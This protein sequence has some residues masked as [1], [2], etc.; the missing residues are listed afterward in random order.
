MAH[1]TG[2]IGA[3]GTFPRK[4]EAE[5]TSRVGMLSQDRTPVCLLTPAGRP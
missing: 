3:G 4:Y 1:A 2:R 5:P